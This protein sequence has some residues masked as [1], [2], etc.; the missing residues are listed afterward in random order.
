MIIILLMSVQLTAKNYKL[1]KYTN[2]YYTLNHMFH[3][4]E[5][6]IEYLFEEWYPEID[7]C[8]K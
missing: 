4:E 7:K 6:I 3:I 8:G 1:R 2:K 5:R